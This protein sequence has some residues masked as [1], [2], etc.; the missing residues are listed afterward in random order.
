[1]LHT[2]RPPCKAANVAVSWVGPG[3]RPDAAAIHLCRAWTACR[4]A[5][6]DFDVAIQRLRGVEP[7]R[8]K[9][10]VVLAGAA[11]PSV[12]HNLVVA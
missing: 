1:M 8:R 6:V 7:D 10:F 9:H 3:N 11:Q 5:D 4:A 2:G 12:I